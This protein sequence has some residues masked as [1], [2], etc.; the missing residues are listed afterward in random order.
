MQYSNS[1]KLEDLLTSIYFYSKMNNDII[2]F[3]LFCLSTKL[4]SYDHPSI[5]GLNTQEE[6]IDFLFK[7][8]TNL[9]EERPVKIIGKKFERTILID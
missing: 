5:R 1:I 9:I 4:I 6:V 2:T 7:V 8:V 3:N